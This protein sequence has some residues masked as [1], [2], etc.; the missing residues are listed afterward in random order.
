[1]LVVISGPSGVGKGTVVGRLLHVI[2]D[3]VFSVSVTTR[4][5]RPS[6]RDGVDYHFVDDER[7]DEM[8]AEGAFL[9]W[10]EYAGRRYGTLRSSVDE[11][12]AAGKVVLLDI[13]VQGA[14]QV[15]RARPD[16]LLVFLL[17]PSEEELLRRLLA[18]GTE[19]EK[20]R[21]LRMEVA[22]AEMGAVERFDVAVVNDDLDRCV[23]EVAE[24][25]D[26]AQ[27]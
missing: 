19:P 26:K 7:F 9:E 3:A 25:I 11:K 5:P 18:R 23:A 22:R 8:V 4:P 1:M 27:V 12:L 14:D 20:V 2:D 21:R 10:A 24:A 13:E 6:E 17:P 16:A 15:R